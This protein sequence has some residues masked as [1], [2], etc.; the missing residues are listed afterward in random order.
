MRM[1]IIMDKIFND[2]EEATVEQQK[3]MEKILEI[4]KAKEEI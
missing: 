1:R 2:S 3:E 4:L